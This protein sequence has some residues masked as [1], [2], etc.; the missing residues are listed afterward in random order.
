MYICDHQIWGLKQKNN[1]DC[2][3][4][5]VKSIFKKPSDRR[6][7]RAASGAGANFLSLGVRFWALIREQLKCSQRTEE[8]CRV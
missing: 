4:F 5:A 1:W 2:F 6:I 3:N 8:L 7:K